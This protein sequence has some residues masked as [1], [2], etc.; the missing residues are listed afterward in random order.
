[1]ALTGSRIGR[2]G[3]EP[4][5]FICPPGGDLYHPNPYRAPLWNDCISNRIGLG[6][7]SKKECFYGTNSECADAWTGPLARSA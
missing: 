1:M 4:A 2:A 3:R 6:H 5:L 7:G